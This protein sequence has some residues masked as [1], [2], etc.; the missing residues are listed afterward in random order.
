[1]LGIISPVAL[2]VFLSVAIGMGILLSVN[3]LMLETLSFRVYD[4]GRDML[5]LFAMAVVENFGYR[6]LNTLWRVR[7]MWQWIRGTKHQWGAMKRSGQ[8]GQA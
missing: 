1:M 3:G 5:V 7:G 6:Q 4:R 8:W 2:V